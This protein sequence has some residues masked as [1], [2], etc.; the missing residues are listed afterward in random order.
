MKKQI[1]KNFNL[2]TNKINWNKIK[3]SFFISTNHINLRLYKFMTTKNKLFKTIKI[4]KNGK[5]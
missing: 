5:R 3:K 1:I 2:I 4:K